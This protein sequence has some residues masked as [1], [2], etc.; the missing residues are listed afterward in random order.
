MTT[1]NFALKLPKFLHLFPKYLYAF[2][3]QKVN[4]KTTKKQR[5]NKNKTK[6]KWRNVFGFQQSCVVFQPHFGLKSGKNVREF[7]EIPNLYLPRTVKAIATS[8]KC[9]I[10]AGLTKFDPTIISLVHSAPSS[11]CPTRQP[12][13]FSI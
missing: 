6:Q 12:T 2:S 3:R 5:K 8:L 4:E 9:L 7:E 1:Q 10:S 13:A 11:K